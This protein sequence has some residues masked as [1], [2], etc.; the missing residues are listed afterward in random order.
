MLTLDDCIALSELR[1]DEV[2]A[3]AEVEHLPSIIAAEL[4]CYLMHLPD[5]ACRVRALIRDDIAEARDAHDFARAARL[6]L[7]LQRFV[8]EHAESCGAAL[9]A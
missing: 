4:G 9:H 7:C 1:P 2:A 5:G 6:R 3:I 8:A